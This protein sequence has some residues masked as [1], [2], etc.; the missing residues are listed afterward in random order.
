M[1]KKNAVAFLPERFREALA[2]A[3]KTQAEL[4]TAVGVSKRTIQRY[5]AGTPIPQSRVRSEICRVLNIN[6]LWVVGHEEQKERT[7]SQKYVDRLI[8]SSIALKKDE[9]L[10]ELAL[11]LME[12]P[13]QDVETVAQALGTPAHMEPVAV[14]KRAKR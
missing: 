11:A 3:G 6:T 8:E 2:S 14:L 10:Y 12:M 5:M 13:G 7:P 4:A 9:Q 1:K